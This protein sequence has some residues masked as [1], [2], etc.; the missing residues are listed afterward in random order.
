MSRNN[1]NTE[2]TSPNKFIELL[3][4]E[5]HNYVGEAGKIYRVNAEETGLEPVAPGAIINVGTGT[6]GN[7]TAW[8][9]G[10]PILRNT[11]IQ[12]KGELDNELVGV[13]NVEA[14]GSDLRLKATGEGLYYVT[15][16]DNWKLPND[17]ATSPGQVLTD[18]AG[19]GITSWETPSAG[20]SDPTNITLSYTLFSY[21]VG[22]Y[23]GVTFMIGSSVANS[24]NPANY[25]TTPHDYGTYTFKA[26]AGTYNVCVTYAEG[27]DRAIVDWIFNGVTTASFDGYSTNV[28]WYRTKQFSVTLVDGDNTL[29][30]SC[31]TKNGSS[32][33]YTFTP[34]EGIYINKI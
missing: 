33:G 11:D 3:D 1:A 16:Q 34:V 2:F 5:I 29:Q 8:G 32:A 18:V 19:D 22:L 4:V 27:T 25:L 6:E 24:I 26:K 13:T 31:T 15:V 28:N 17:A 23:A 7:L 20:G 14:Q 30:I 10:A 21:F 9:N 12:V